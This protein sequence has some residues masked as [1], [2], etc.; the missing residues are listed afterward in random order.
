LYGHRVPPISQDVTAAM[1][2]LLVTEN[3]ENKVDEE[4][5]DMVSS[6]SFFEV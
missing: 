4:K 5:S 1:L 2:V 6:S 3:G